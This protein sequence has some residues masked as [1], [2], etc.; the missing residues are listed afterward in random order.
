[1]F[2]NLVSRQLKEFLG[3]PRKPQLQYTPFENYRAYS[4][5]TNG[6]LIT[7]YSVKEL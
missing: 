5:S 1:M 3:F 4:W 7:V 6:I 2:C